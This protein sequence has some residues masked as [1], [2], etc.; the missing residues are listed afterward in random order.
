MPVETAKAAGRRTLKFNTLDD[1]LADV[2]RLNAGNVRV[3]GNWSKGQILKHLAILMNGCIDGIPFKAPLYMA[4]A[5]GC[6]R[7]AS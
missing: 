3:L 7:T 6:S 2:E 5:R 1:I 4:P